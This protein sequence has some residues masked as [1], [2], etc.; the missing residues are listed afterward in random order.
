MNKFKEDIEAHFKMRGLITPEGEL[1]LREGSEYDAQIMIDQIG[2]LIEIQQT[3]A[4]AVFLKSSTLDFDRIDELEKE[5][6]GL[7]NLLREI[8][9]DSRG[10]GNGVNTHL[11]NKILGAI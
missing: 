7:K 8:E 3:K 5:L 1:T 6:K 10:S 11:Y 9:V 4:T 2:Q